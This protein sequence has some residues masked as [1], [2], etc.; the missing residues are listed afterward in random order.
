MNTPDTPP[1]YYSAETYVAWAESLIELMGP[2]WLIE[3]APKPH[4]TVHLIA[5]WLH[6]YQTATPETL[7]PSQQLL[8]IGE[9]MWNIEVI[10][11]AGVM[12]VETRISDLRLDDA[13][14]VAS[15]IHEIRIAA[16]FIAEG[17]RV[18]FIP[19]AGS[20][21]PDMLID[22]G[23]EVECKH[24]CRIS[25][26]DRQRYEL[27][28]ILSRRL[29]SVFHDK[30]PHSLLAIEI[31]FHK[32][33]SR[34]PIDRVVATARQALNDPKLRKFS[35][36]LTGEYSAQF[37]TF[38][39]GDGPDGLFLP[40]EQ[41]QSKFD[42]RSTE[43][44]VINPDGP[45][46]GRFINLS[47]GCEVRQDRVKGNVKSLKSSI[48]QLSGRYPAIVSID[49]SET[50]NDVNGDSMAHL[51]DDLLAVMRNNSK[52]S[53][54]RLDSTVLHQIDGRDV[55]GSFTERIDNPYARHPLTSI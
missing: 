22:D 18:L 43:G 10:Q 49:I 17:R 34:P 47:V 29:R 9:L 16:A 13:E 39:M 38:A 8:Q 54:V 1:N 32:E 48:G 6:S 27:Y 40:R 24:K 35:E 3:H 55:Y 31:V 46:L 15:A 42:Q 20:R 14:R 11:N 41:G 52:I 4:R 28:G 12:N 44:V 36:A 51:R 21:T 23:I 7:H 33:P 26:R 25:G 2:E 45:I 37:E 30:V 50:V 53:Q 19:E 5:S